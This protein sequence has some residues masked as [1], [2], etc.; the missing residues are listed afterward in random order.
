MTIGVLSAQESYDLA[1][2][3]VEPARPRLTPY[4]NTAEAVKGGAESRFVAVVETPTAKVEGNK[5]TFSTFYIMPIN[6][7]N[8][9]VILRVASA[10]TAYTLYV[11]GREV[12][13]SPTGARAAEFNITKASAGAVLYKS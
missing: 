4:H 12:G 5:S 1:A 2:R 9:Q 7:L 10:S 13:F 6:W 11:K 3:N 8:R